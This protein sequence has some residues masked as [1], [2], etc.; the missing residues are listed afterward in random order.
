MRRVYTIVITALIMAAS[1]VVAQTP[2]RDRPGLAERGTASIA[3]TVIADDERR[4]PLRRVLLTLSRAGTEDIRRSATDDAG[5]FAFGGLPAGTY[6]L[7]AAKG[8]YVSRTFGALQPG[9]PGSSI[10]VIDGARFS[11]PP[12]PLLRGA[13][14]AGRV[15]DRNGRPAARVRIQA[16]QVV[17]IEGEVRP[18]NVS[19]ASGSSLTNAHGEY[20]I[21]GLLPGEYVVSASGLGLGTA[22]DLTPAELSWVQQP[23]GPMP[24]PGPSFNYAPTF[25]PGTTDV[26]GATPIALS[27]SE[28][29]V[30]V[31]FRVQHVP[32]AR[33][34]G[35]ITDAAGRPVQGA[36]V[37][38]VPRRL[39]GIQSPSIPVARSDSN[40][41]FVFGDTAPG[42]YT[43]VVRIGSSG[44]AAV[45]KSGTPPATPPAW[46][47]AD[48]RVSG[49][50]LT[51][52]AIRLQPGMALSGRVTFAAGTAPIDFARIGIRLVGT[53]ITNTIYGQSS[54]VAADGAF[55]LGGLM[56][57]SYR[58]AAT[59]PVGST[60]FARSAIYRGTDLI[61]VATTIRPNEDV[62]D[63]VVT[64][65]D[66]PSAL[67]GRLVDGAGQPAPQFYVFAFP[68]DKTAWV[69]G[70]RRIASARADLNGQYTLSPLVP[71]EYF[72]CAVTE[73]ETA[74]QF[75]PT[76]LEQFVPAA[77]R[78]T[79][80]EG[81]KRVQDLKV[82]R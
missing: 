65:S 70:A 56:P 77:I 79:I 25:F 50:D 80:G 41:S 73:F 18:R 62:S 42:D 35:L 27:R 67:S 11:A 37:T 40:G 28:E 36:M 17:T 29:R 26:F 58:V 72:L 24:P 7:S 75:D 64:L 68:T 21:F 1:I 48:I 81:E 61:D 10:T 51:D 63:V 33:V 60:V 16:E 49:P 69:Q 31:D 78:I 82:G 74:L 43:I 12:I 13:V 19:G 76:Y 38:R 20:R 47:M 32:M 23:T 46:G 53:D 71:G 15:F 2:V 39:R 54:P 30:D 22:R 8:G 6:T 3:G 52:I 4:Q 55:Q 5:R 44:S 9:L 34:S 45:I 14:I 66:R 57:G 59:L